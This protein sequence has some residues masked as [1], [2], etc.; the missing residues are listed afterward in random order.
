M[1]DKQLLEQELEVQ[2]ETTPCDN[3]PKPAL[4]RMNS[5]LECKDG[6][7]VEIDDIG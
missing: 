5:H 1:K 7:W 4:T 2:S 3:L 6:A